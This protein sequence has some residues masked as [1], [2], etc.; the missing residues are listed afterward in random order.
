MPTPG[1]K[2]NRRPAD[3]VDAFPI[4]ENASVVAHHGVGPGLGDLPFVTG[5]PAPVAVGSSKDQPHNRL[6]QGTA[7]QP[8]H[9]G[10]QSNA[11]AVYIRPDR[12]VN[13]TIALDNSPS[14]PSLANFADILP[15]SHAKQ[16]A[17]SVQPSKQSPWASPA[18]KRNDQQSS[19]YA[20]PGAAAP[21]PT[22]QYSAVLSPA[23]ASQEALQ[24][25][26][27]MSVSDSELTNITKLLSTHPWAEPELARAVLAAVNHN[28]PAADLLLREME[29][30]Q[31]PSGSDSDEDLANH[32][33]PQQTLASQP[34]N[35]CETLSEQCSGPPASPQ[36]LKAP[37]PPSSK[38][39]TRT[40]S[41][42]R[43]KQSSEEEDADVDLYYKHRG[44]ASKL[45]RRW[46]KKLH[47][48]ANAFAAAQ[49][50][51]GKAMATEAHQIRLR[52]QAAHAEAAQNIE[53]ANN[54]GRGLGQNEIDLHGLHALEAVEALDRRLHSLGQSQHHS[55]A[56]KLRVIVGRGNNSSGGEASLPRVIES[57]LL[58]RNMN[59]ITGQGVITVY[60]RGLRH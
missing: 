57:H 42:R 54:A 18:A 52:A 47:Q 53:S 21:K 24:P 45:S 25:S 46:H 2:P 33:I 55:Q 30:H 4:L 43:R 6:Q 22:R 23:K 28:I 38:V 27:G 17:K 58:Q 32:A 8:D 11:S 35:Q 13:A 31:A 1:A 51:E 56:A 3:H 40:L 12:M 49:F 36:T 16:P 41:S 29:Q 48:A 14:F 10:R 39:P 60:L 26:C 59:Y 44:E 37:A 20:S 50:S 34:G 7:P 9:K 19:N 15:T 5:A